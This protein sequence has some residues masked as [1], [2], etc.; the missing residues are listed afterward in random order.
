MSLVI[1]LALALAVLA[2]LDG[3]IL[4]IGR[5]MA[6]C[7]QT[8]RTARAASVTIATGF[9]AIGAGAVLLIAAGLPLLGG[10]LA[11]TLLA[12][13]LAALFLGLGFTHAMTLLRAVLPVA[14]D[15]AQATA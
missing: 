5:R 13:G 2:A 9:A 14:Q 7:P 15:R 1:Y 8:G 12:S 6:D 4:S 10:G 3:M 11:A